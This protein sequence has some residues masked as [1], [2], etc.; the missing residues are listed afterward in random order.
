MR[1]LGWLLVAALAVAAA[2]LAYMGLSGGPVSVVSLALNYPVA[3]AIVCVLAVVG[4]LTG[5]VAAAGCA[6]DE[7]IARMTREQLYR[8]NERGPHGPEGWDE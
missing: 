5:V 6:S 1:T 8:I 4:L 7:E 2:W 3:F